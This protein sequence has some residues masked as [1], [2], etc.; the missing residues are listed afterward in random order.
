MAVKKPNETLQIDALKQGRVTL[1]LIGTTPLYMNSMSAKAKRS[2]LIGGG[3]KTAAEKRDIKHDP[4]TEFRASMYRQETGDTLLC[5]PAPGIK[6]AMATGALETPGVTKSSVQ[7]LIFLPQQKINIWGRPLLKCDTV[8]SADMA[9]TPDIRTRA[10]LPRWCAE[11]DIAFVSLTLSAHS[12]VSLLSN[13]G[14][15]CG[16][17][18]Y[19]QEKGKGGFG[20]FSVHGE[21]LGDWQHEWDEI[22]AD[23]RDAQQDAY[24]NPEYADQ[25]TADLMEMLEDERLIRAA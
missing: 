9:R 6:A 14:V 16:I 5:F 11:V 25:D 4:E 19:R 12:I 1:R 18:D 2:L 17:G 7:R 23:A 3:R 8:R 13:A 15:V 21:D 22:T 20:T 24:D 10:F